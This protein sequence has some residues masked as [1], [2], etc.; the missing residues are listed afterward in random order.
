[1][2]ELV[3]DEMRTDI[4]AAM[5]EGGRRQLRRRCREAN[6]MVLHSEEFLWTCEPA[7]SHP[8]GGFARG[9]TELVPAPQ[10]RILLSTGKLRHFSVIH[11]T[12][13]GIFFWCPS[14]LR[15]VFVLL[16]VHLRIAPLPRERIAPSVSRASMVTRKFQAFA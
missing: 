2:V 5:T 9:N 3:R 10:D 1:M 15:G 11:L 12:E 7:W 14:I 13:H 4:P 8:R 16:L 6:S